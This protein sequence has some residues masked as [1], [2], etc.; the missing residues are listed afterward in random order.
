MYENHPKNTRKELEEEVASSTAT[1]G[2]SSTTYPATTVHDAFRS[3]HQGR[4]ARF[5]VLSILLWPFGIAWNITWSILSLACN[6]F[7]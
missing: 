2:I 4:Q 3:S 1:R 7:A 6:V 5:N